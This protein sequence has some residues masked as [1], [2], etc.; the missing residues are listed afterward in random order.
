MNAIAE[1]LAAAA[2]TPCWNSAGHFFRTAES[3]ECLWC[4]ATRERRVLTV[5]TS[6]TSLSPCSPCPPCEPKPRET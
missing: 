1:A 5:I 3:T 4:G 2:E 6:P